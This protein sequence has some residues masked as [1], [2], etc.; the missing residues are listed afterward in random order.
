MFRDELPEFDERD[1]AQVLSLMNSIFGEYVV[2]LQTF[3]DGHFRVIFRR[4][5]FTLHEGAVE[6]TKSQWS[7]LKKRIKRRDRLIFIFKQTGSV[8]CSS[9]DAESERRC[10]Y[11]DFGY[12]FA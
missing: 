11:L 5:Y 4:D 8:T 12:F 1:F 3:E 6:P 7:S 10:Y 2:E 9:Q